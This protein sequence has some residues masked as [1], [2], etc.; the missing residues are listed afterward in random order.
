MCRI[1][2]LVGWQGV[3]IDHF[4]GCYRAA[5]RIAENNYVSVGKVLRDSLVQLSGTLGDALVV[6]IVLGRELDDGVVP[7]EHRLPCKIR[8]R[9]DEQAHDLVVIALARIGRAGEAHDQCG[10]VIPESQ[11]G[12]QH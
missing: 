6:I 8:C 9:R 12:V 10:I 1:G 5:F 2:L 11:R 3:E 7:G 4:L